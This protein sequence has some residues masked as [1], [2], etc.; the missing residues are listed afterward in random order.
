MLARRALTAGD[1][2]E[3]SAREEVWAEIV[4][5]FSLEL[6]PHFAIEEELVLPAIEA[7]GE[8]ELAERIRDEHATLRRLV[9]EAPE[10]LSTRLSDFGATLRDHVRFE[11]R[12]LF[13]V[14]QEKVGHEVLEAIAASCQRWHSAHHGDN[15]AS[16]TEDPEPREVP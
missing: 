13:P 8:R 10:P 7:A 5:R 12:V 3:P 2:D 9:Q 11:E 16:G 6:L 4:K 15:D 14:V 1:R